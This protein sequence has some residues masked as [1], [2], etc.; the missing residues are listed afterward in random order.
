MIAIIDYGMGNLKSIQ[1]MFGRIGV[2]ADIS[3]SR[4]MISSAEKLVL[5]GVG[6]FGNAMSRLN[7]MEITFI[8][9][10]RVIEWK[11]PILGICLGMQ[12]L[13]QRSQ[14][15]GEHAGLGFLDA[16]T[17]RFDFSTNDKPLKVPHM[18]WNEIEVRK[19]S[20]LTK[21]LEVD[22]RFYFVHSYHVNCHIKESIVATTHYGFDF[23]SMI[24]HE[25]I[26]GVQFH[27]EKSHRF[28]MRVLEN[29]AK[30]GTSEEG[31]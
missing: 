22:S 29:F 24:Q 20:P 17:I 12:L 25:N 13:S 21:S 28:G 7:D 30:L 5:P 16:E 14:E 6:A 23:V 4:E 1:N 19:Q 18:G 8:L 3:S 11:I 26:F 15:G 10:E 27:P 31:G 2:E 9:Q